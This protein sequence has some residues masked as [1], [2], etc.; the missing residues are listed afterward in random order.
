MLGEVSKR[1][2]GLPKDDKYGVEIMDVRESTGVARAFDMVRSF[3]Q[4]LSESRYDV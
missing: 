3:G 1:S 2:Q 4:V